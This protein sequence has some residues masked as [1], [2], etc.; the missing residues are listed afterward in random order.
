M[1]GS[2]IR[3]A[4]ST[5][6]SGGWKRCSA[7]LARRDARAGSSSVT[8]PV[9]TLFMWMPSCVVVGRGGARHHVERRL[10]HVGVRVRVG[11]EVAVELPFHRRHVDDVLVAPGVAQHQ[12]LEPGVEDEGAT[13]LTS[14]TSSSSTAGTSASSSARSSARADPPAAG[15]DRAALREEMLLRARAPQAAA[16]PATA[17]P[18]CASPATLGSRRSNAAEVDR[19]A[20]PALEL[21]VRAAPALVGCRAG[22]GPASGRSCKRRASRP[23]SCGGR[24][25]GGRRTV[26]QALLMM[27]SSRSRVA[28]QLVGR[29]PRRSACG[30][31]RGRRSR[32]DRAHSAKSGSRGVARRRVA[33]EAGGD[34]Q[35]RAG[36]QQLDARLVADLDPPAGEQRHPAA[37]VGQSRCAWRS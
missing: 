22:G 2:T 20:G 18:Q 24:S 26:W 14:C 29:K 8:Q 3:A 17:R 7:V 1:I 9:S 33:R 19:H 28:E 34:D 12:R 25:S 35:A 5:M 11:L 10:G 30:A 4:P 15:P 6:S 16:A 27:K 32:A 13:A 37:Q 21:Q 23:P 36:A 31:D